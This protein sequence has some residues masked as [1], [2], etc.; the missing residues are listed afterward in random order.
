MRI[1]QKALFS[2]KILNMAVTFLCI[3]RVVT[4]LMSTELDIELLRLRLCCTHAIYYSTSPTATAAQHM[5]QNSMI[6][7][8]RGLCG[9]A[10]AKSLELLFTGLEPTVSKFGRCVDE[11]ELDLLKSRPLGAREQGM[12][13]SN[14]TL[15]GSGNGTLH[16][17]T[18]H[19]ST[20]ACFE[21]LQR[22]TVTK[23]Q[24]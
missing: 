7:L 10:P 15:L 18:Q 24:I 23:L 8:G 16:A 2:F 5:V 3:L 19:W 14:D 11:L 6:K 9:L 20:S 12:S 17:S 21:L 13:Q 4:C 1:C 22:L